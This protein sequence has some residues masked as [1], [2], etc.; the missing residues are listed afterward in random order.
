[1]RKVLRDAAGFLYYVSVTGVTGVRPMV[2][3]AVRPVIEHLRTSTQLP[4]GVGFGISTPDQ[5]AAVSRF[6]DAVVVGSAVM[7]V[8]DAHRGSSTLVQEVGAF[9]RRLKEAM[10]N[11]A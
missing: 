1:V 4:I 5:A 11:G 7:R 6:A 3:E 2:A 8:V 10:R 9:I